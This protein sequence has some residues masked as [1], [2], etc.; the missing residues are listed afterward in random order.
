[1]YLCTFTLLKFSGERNFGVALNKPFALRLPVDVPLFQGNHADLLVIVLHKLIVSGLDKLSALYNCFLTIICNISPYC[2]SFSSVASV[3]LVNLFELFTSTRF[4]YASEGNHAYVS[5]L[6]E[7]FNN[8]VQYQY[9]GNVNLVY[10]IVRR[11]GVFE[12]VAKLT[13]PDAIRRASELAAKR[14]GEGSTGKG[15]AAAAGGASSGAGGKKAQGAGAAAAALSKGP[16]GKGVAANGSK[17]DGDKEKESK[18]LPEATTPTVRNNSRCVAVNL[19]RS[20]KSYSGSLP[21]SLLPLS[22]SLFLPLKVTLK[23]T[24]TL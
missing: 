14:G 5:L 15:A 16:N 23:L 10:A 9:E 18:E 24:L 11:K 13:L 1:M 2:K 22:F 7:T 21:L 4:L 12:T 3:K 8:I 20:Y 17:T 6:L 19:S